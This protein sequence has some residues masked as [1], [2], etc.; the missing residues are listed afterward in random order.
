MI[1]ENQNTNEDSLLVKQLAKG[2]EAAFKVLYDKYYNDI[3]AFSISLLKS[4]SKAEGVLQEV[5]LNCWLKRKNMNPKLSFKSYIFTCTKNA[6]LNILKK[7]ARENALKSSIFNQAVFFKNDTEDTLVNT[8]YE[9][10]RQQ[11]IESLP[12]KRKLIFQMSRRDGKSYEDISK[13]LDLSI[14]TVKNQMSKALKSIKTYLH[15]H[16]DLNIRLSLLIY[17]TFISK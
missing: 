2:N 17:F 4:S 15:V 13:E 12:P 9:T 10:L 11:A 8:E 1:S 7:E 5:F 3:Y 14:S 6:A 16:S